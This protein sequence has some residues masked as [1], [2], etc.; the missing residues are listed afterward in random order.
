MI[1]PQTFIDPIDKT[2]SVCPIPM[3]NGYL[4]SLKHVYNSWKKDGVKHSSIDWNTIPPFKLPGSTDNQTLALPDQILL[5]HHIALDIGI[6]VEPPFKVQ[7]NMQGQEDG[8]SDI[9]LTDQIRIASV[10]YQMKHTQQ[11]VSKITK[12]CIVHKTQLLVEV[13]LEQNVFSFKIKETESNPM[14]EIPSRLVVSDSS[15]ELF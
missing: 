5:I 14:T 12:Y 2:T 11:E 8:W 4:I 7:Y 13:A 10:M 9:M 15:Y 3:S 6:S 1:P